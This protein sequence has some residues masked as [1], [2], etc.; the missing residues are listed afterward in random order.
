VDSIL[1][2]RVRQH[3]GSKTGHNTHSYALRFSLDPEGSHLVTCQFIIH[4]DP[5]DLIQRRVAYADDSWSSNNCVE[6]NISWETICRSANK[7]GFLPIL[8]PASPLPWSQQPATGLHPQPDGPS[9]HLH[10]HTVTFW[11]H[12]NIILP[13][14][15]RSSEWS[16]QLGLCSHLIVH[17]ITLAAMSRE[18]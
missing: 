5:C 1:L 13:P 14:A 11:I 7:K 17:N 9:S 16:L 2:L 6:Q 12:F 10:T 15:S 8:E 18:E 4:N 3:L